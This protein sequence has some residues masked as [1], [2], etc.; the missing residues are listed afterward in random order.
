VGAEVLRGDRRGQCGD[1]GNTG[2][3]TTKP[4]AERKEWRSLL[5]LIGAI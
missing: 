1:G 3:R 5:E 2:V 4:R